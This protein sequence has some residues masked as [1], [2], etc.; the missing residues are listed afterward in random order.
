MRPAGRDPPEGY[1]AA[2]DK[3]AA[4]LKDSGMDFKKS[5]PESQYTKTGPA[6][7]IRLRTG[8]RF[9]ASRSGPDVFR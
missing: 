3:P 1:M 4:E 7:V 2:E 6:A 8:D 9:A 5:I